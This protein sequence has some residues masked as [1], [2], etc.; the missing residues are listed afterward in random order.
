MADANTLTSLPLHVFD[1]ENPPAKRLYRQKDIQL[2]ADEEAR[3]QRTLLEYG[4][5]AAVGLALIQKKKGKKGGKGDEED[6]EDSEEAAKEQ[7]RISQLMSGMDAMA[8]GTAVK[9]ANL[10]ALMSM[11]QEEIQKAS[12]LY[13]DEKKR[14]EE[15]TSK[16]QDAAQK[17]LLERLHQQINAKKAFVAVVSSSSHHI[18]SL[19]LLSA[20]FS[21]W[22]LTKSTRSASSTARKRRRSRRWK[23]SSL[24]SARRS[25]TSRLRKTSRSALP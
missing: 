25:P 13:S 24:D 7:R 14:T 10:G 19:S 5:S 9:A 15:N 4:R 18:S 2:D 20:V 6:E 16:Q 17:A 12:S 11:G 3:V 8:D 23:P 1:H 22:Q 21:R